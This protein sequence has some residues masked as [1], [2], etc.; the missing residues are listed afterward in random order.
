M[1]KGEECQQNRPP[2]RFYLQ[3]GVLGYAWDRMTAGQDMSD[4]IVRPIILSGGAGTRLWPVSRLAFPKQLLPIAADRTMDVVEQ[5][6]RRRGRDHKPKL[7]NRFHI[8]M[9]KPLTK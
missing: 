6:D 7:A 9:V 3:S 2:V 8:P 5:R 1:L 4:T